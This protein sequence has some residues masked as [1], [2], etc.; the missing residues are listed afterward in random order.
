M[1]VCVCVCV[2]ACVRARAPLL[3]DLGRHVQK[4]GLWGLESKLFKSAPLGQIAIILWS[5]KRNVFE[6]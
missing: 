1:C 2:C 6:F 4:G 5:I 3:A